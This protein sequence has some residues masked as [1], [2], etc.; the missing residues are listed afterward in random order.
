MLTFS[1]D[2]RAVKFI[3][4]DGERERRSFRP[5]QGGVCYDRFLCPVAFGCALSEEETSRGRENEGH[6]E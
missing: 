1:V 4:R 5:K 3:L 6:G 2:T